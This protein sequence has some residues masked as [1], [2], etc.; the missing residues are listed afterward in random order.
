MKCV[1]ENVRGFSLSSEITCTCGLDVCFCSC[2]KM[3]DF[4][5]LGFFVCMVLKPLSHLQAGPKPGS[6]DAP[7]SASRVA[8][9]YR[10]A[11]FRLAKSTGF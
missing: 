6:S 11:P 4:L 1:T 5:V 2:A 8:G 7:D 10:H 3:Q 9:N